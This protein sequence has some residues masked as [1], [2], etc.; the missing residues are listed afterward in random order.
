METNN[1]KR[2]RIRIKIKEARKNFG[3]VVSRGEN[4]DQ[5][6]NPSINADTEESKTSEGSKFSAMA[7]FALNKQ[8]DGTLDFEE[9]TTGWWNM[10]MDKGFGYILKKDYDLHS[11][12]SRKEYLEFLRKPIPSLALKNAY[13]FRSA[14]YE[15]LFNSNDIVRV[16][17]RSPVVLCFEMFKSIYNAHGGHISIPD[18]IE[19]PCDR[20]CV[21]IGG[22]DNNKRIFKFINSWGE[23]WGDKGWGYLPYDYVDKY[24][25]ESWVSISNLSI[26]SK[27]GDIKH[28]G[29]FDFKYMAYDSLVQF[30]QPTFIIDAYDKD[31]IVGWIHFRFNDLAHSIVIEELFVKPNFRKQSIARQLLDSVEDIARKYLIPEIV[32][33]IHVQDILFE[34]NIYAIENLFDQDKGYQITP[35]N[36]QFRGCIYKVVKDDFF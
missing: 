14:W 5:L 31:L 12:P 17:P 13:I 35:Y 20:H 32:S 10:R 24:L 26:D 9:G 28:I 11:D 27:K 19:K 15:R 23:E 3:T 29:K 7:S 34:D 2:K 25:I 8:L 21:M 33:Y 6:Q 4:K 1:K 16:L 30:R 22:Y 18:N 36:Q